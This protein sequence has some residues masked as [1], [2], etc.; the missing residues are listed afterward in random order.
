MVIIN[1]RDSLHCNNGYLF[2]YCSCMRFICLK[3]KFKSRTYWISIGIIGLGVTKYHFQGCFL[4]FGVFS[5]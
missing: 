5:K 3:S 4:K 2:I 1:S